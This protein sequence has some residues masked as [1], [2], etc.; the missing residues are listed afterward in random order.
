MGNDLI[1]SNEEIMNRQQ[2]SFVEAG[3]RARQEFNV[4]S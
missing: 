4:K 2:F 3:N 1:P